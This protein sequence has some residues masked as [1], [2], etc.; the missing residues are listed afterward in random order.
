M[1]KSKHTNVKYLVNKNE[2]CKILNSNSFKNIN[3]LGQELYEV[4]IY[5]SRISVDTPTQIVFSYFTICKVKKFY[6]DCLNLYLKKIHSNL[7]KPIKIKFT[8]Q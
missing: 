5:K 1:D 3:K 6:Y 2:V 7:L 8:W 4:E